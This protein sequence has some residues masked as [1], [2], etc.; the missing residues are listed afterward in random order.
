M[1]ASGSGAAA[2]REP[3]FT[4]SCL[5]RPST[6]WPTAARWPGGTSLAIPRDRD[7]LDRE[8][9]CPWSDHF[10]PLF[11]QGDALYVNGVM[12]SDVEGINTAALHA[13]RA[14]TTLRSHFATFKTSYTQALSKFTESFKLDAM[15][16]PNFVGRNAIILYVHCFFQSDT[17]S[18]LAEMATRLR[19]D[20]AQCDAGVAGAAERGRTTSPSRTSTCMA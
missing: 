11:N 7:Q 14:P 2:G 3:T 13:E 12:T 16:F 9:V 18:V 10:S 15:D 8:V 1:T 5:E 19:P 20:V 4:S 17:G 6:S